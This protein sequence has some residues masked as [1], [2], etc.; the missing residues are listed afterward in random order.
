MAI[1]QG[2]SSGNGLEIDS[3]KH[4]L[5][6]ARPPAFGALGY[7]RQAMVTGAVAA[8]LGAGSTLFSFRW[9]D[10]TRLCLI[11][12]IRVNA[13]VSGLITTGVQ[14]D[15]AAFIA[16]SFTASDTGGTASLP[17]S[18]QQKLRTSMGNSLAGDVR[19]A[20]TAALGVGTRTVDAFPIG[21]IVGFTGTTVGTQV[22]GSGS[23]AIPL[24]FRDNSDHH[25][26]VLAQNEGILVQNPLAGPATG[27][28]TMLVKIEWGEVASY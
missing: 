5:S 1:I 4:V 20:A 8:T 22:F 27:T 24:Y 3:D 10:A 15:L 14:F 2:V 13:I 25:P 6:N 16:R 28:L 19:I 21:R 17:A 18:G 12:S 7:Y 26:I 11:Q 9:T 23:D